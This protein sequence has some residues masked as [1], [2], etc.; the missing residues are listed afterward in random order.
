MIDARF[1]PMKER[2]NTAGEYRSPGRGWGG[3]SDT[4]GELLERELLALDATDIVVE[5]GFDR[6][7]IRNDGWPRSGCTP[8]W[9]DIRLYMETRHGPLRYEC[10]AFDHWEQNLHAIAL[11]LQRQRLAL[12]E[13]GIGTGG[14]AYRGFAALPS[15]RDAA[16]ETLARLA[17]LPGA[18]ALT[19]DTDLKAV[20]RQAAMRCHP[21]RGGNADDMARLNNAAGEL[22]L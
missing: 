13:W 11:W 4:R 18:A 3:R 12:E 5:C 16:L 14:E 6:S 2:I 21:D 17:G 1:Q 8:R 20:Y 9:P 7:Q 10:A 19:A 22:G 15:A